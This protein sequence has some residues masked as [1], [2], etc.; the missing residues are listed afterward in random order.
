MS[1]SDKGQKKPGVSLDARKETILSARREAD[2][3]MLFQKCGGGRRVIRK[4]SKE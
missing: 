2:R 4:R 3:Y 1:K